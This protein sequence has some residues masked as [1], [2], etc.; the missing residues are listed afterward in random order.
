MKFFSIVFLL[1]STL[2][3]SCTKNSNVDQKVY[4]VDVKNYIKEFCASENKKGLEVL[5]KQKFPAVNLLVTFYK[6]RNY[7]SVWVKNQETTPVFKKALDLLRHSMSYGLD[8][9]MYA[10]KVIGNASDHLSKNELSFTSNK[11]IIATELLTTH[12]L[13]L[14]LQH[15]QT[16]VFAPD[17]AFYDKIVVPDCEMIPTVLEK[18]VQAS[19]FS[20]ALDVVSPKNPHYRD[21]Q[22]A[23]SK[24]L[25]TT[26]IN[27]IKHPIPY[28]AKDSTGC[29][30]GV[31]K[32]LQVHGYLAKL[33]EKDPTKVTSALVKFQTDFGLRNRGNYDTL[34]VETLGKSTF[35]FYRSACITL[36]RLRWS[37]ISDKFYLLVNIP[38]FTLHFVEEG[39]I[40]LIHKIVCG[41]PDH[42]TPELNSRMSHFILFPEWNVPHK[43]SSKEL[44]PNIK[45]NPGYLQKHNYELINGKNEVVDV[46][47]INFKKYS[48]KNFPFRLRQGGGEGNSLGIIKFHFNNKHSVYLHDTP[49]KG[50]FNLNYRAFSHG[51]MRV[52]NPFGFAKSLL[53]FNKG[54]LHLSKEKM[55]KLNKYDQQ[56]KF[57][58]YRKGNKSYNEAEQ[59]P[60]VKAM[61]K[62]VVDMKSTIFTISR[63][64]PLYIRYFTTFVDEK[65]NLK[66]HPDLYHKEKPL[67]EKFDNAVEA[68]SIFK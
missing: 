26:K 44:L 65:S 50:L 2:F 29:K 6:N 9:S 41:K 34:T 4:S 5:E 42:E 39:E 49:S 27:K 38:S 52:Q 68:N 40:S 8:N 23:L 63:P 55:V 22:Q 12:S 48:E 1:I 24:Y 16:G 59:L 14:F 45:A 58:K 54:M 7:Q 15:V 28:F 3:I 60:Q 20:V 32:M 67:I 21:I 61:E 36:Q 10:T 56:Q 62:D 25:E 35:D 64:L 51:C 33:D 11:N 57:N 17:S 31:K 43:I 30:I 46:S 66:F 37:D 13:L 18:A 19:D 47:T 53:E